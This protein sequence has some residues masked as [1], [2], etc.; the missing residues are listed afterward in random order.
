MRSTHCFLTRAYRLARDAGW[1]HLP[2]VGAVAVLLL[3]FVLG[4]G[5]QGQ[6]ETPAGDRAAPVSF[7][8]TRGL[9]DVDSAW[10]VYHS[11]QQLNAMR[12]Q[13]GLQAK[14][15]GLPVG[16]QVESKDLMPKVGGLTPG[17]WKWL[18]PGNVGGTTLALLPHSKEPRILYAGSAH[19]GLWKTDN[20][21]DRWRI[22]AE[23]VGGA[24]TVAVS[25][26]AAD[27]ANPDV[28]YV[29]TGDGKDSRGLPGIGILKTTDGGASWKLLSRSLNW[30][31]INQLAVSSDGRVVLAGTPM[32]LMRT[33]N[34][35]TSWVPA[36][37]IGEIPIQEVHFHPAAAKRCVAGGWRGAA[38]YSNDGGVH[39]KRSTGLPILRGQPG[40]GQG[41]VALACAAGAA[42][43]VYASVD[44]D[45]GRLYRSNDGGQ[46]FQPAGNDEKYLEGYGYAAHCLWAGDPTRPDLVVVG[47][48]SLWRSTDG[49]RNLEKIGSWD[50][51]KPPQTRFAF[52]TI[53][54]HPRYNGTENRTLYVGSSGG[55]DR[56][57]DI[58]TASLTEGWQTLN[59][60]YGSTEIVGIAGDAGTGTLVAGCETHGTLLS[61]GGENKWSLVMGGNGGFCAVDF[62]DKPCVY[63]SSWCLQL[64]QSLDGGKTA[65][66]IYD[67]IKDAQ[68]QN[69]ALTAAPFVLDP[70]NAKVMLAGGKSLWRCTDTQA[71]APVWKSVKMST[72]QL[73]SALAVAPGSS[74]TI[75][76]GYQNG[77][78]SQTSNGRAEQPTWRSIS[79]TQLPRKRYC[80][81]IVIDPRNPQRVFVTFWGYAANNLWRTEDGG[82]A[83]TAVPIKAGG[84]KQLTAP[85]ND[86]AIHPSNPR[87]LYLATQV[88]IFASEDGGRHWSPTNEGPTN[89]AVQQLLWM[90]KTLVAATYGRGVFQ[91]DLSGVRAAAP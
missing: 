14:V 65:R 2:A 44:I 10:D 30:Y 86:L 85:L 5:G 57:D 90:N 70:N 68:N 15:A 64:Y 54:S 50:K 3:L 31:W 45:G 58:T 74:D 37:D 73:I 38:Y 25:C 27:P 34:G 1:L 41:R 62:R 4:L 48:F 79:D 77:S 32:G 22:V 83:W 6:E 24:G 16:V 53:V 12:Q 35:G 66:W 13:V 81:R 19:G 72:G 56:I 80:S 69:A 42:D 71:E 9:Q 67:G 20:G 49:G 59:N 78:L 51:V 76:V 46:T 43:V 84:A 29:G 26:L 36:A 87:C 11:L 89:C 52:K 8:P 47:S 21:G 18:G 33:G 91:I 17:G 40:D 82:N 88:G 60:G 39:W 7:A 75:W 61:R 55:V 28:I 63:G 23:L